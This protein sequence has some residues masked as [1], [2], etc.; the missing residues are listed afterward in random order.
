V[1]LWITVF[2][3]TL[4]ET[5]PTELQEITKKQRK[6]KKIRNDSSNAAFPLIN[7]FKEGK[8]S[9]EEFFSMSSDLEKNFLKYENEA[10][11]LFKEIRSIQSKHKTFGFD[12]YNIFSFQLSIQII[13]FISILVLI[14]AIK[15]RNKSKTLLRALNI[16]TCNFLIIS[17]FY[18]TWVFYKGDDMEYWA[19]ISFISVIAIGS[20]IT[21]YLLINWLYNSIE[22]FKM[23]DHEFIQDAKYALELLK[24]KVKEESLK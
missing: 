7:S 2:H 11:I 12:S 21:V 22:K 16:V 8:L 5:V 10:S 4:Y 1:I 23:K 13:F 20:G 9:K 3:H 14:V 17:A 19:Y 24:Q 18:T 15:V 6:A